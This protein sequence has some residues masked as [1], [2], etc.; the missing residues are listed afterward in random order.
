MSEASTG[1]IWRVLGSL[2]DVPIYVT[3]TIGTTSA[4]GGI[5]QVSGNVSLSGSNNFVQIA[6]TG[7]NFSAELVSALSGSNTLDFD[8]TPFGGTSSGFESASISKA[9]AGMFYEAIVSNMSSS[10]QYF[11]LFDRTTTPPNGEPPAA[12][13]S[14]YVAASSSISISPRTGHYFTA[15]IVWGWST[16]YEFFTG[17]YAGSAIVYTK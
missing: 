7:S 3:G 4:A 10:A 8:A 1:E 2:P 9:T 5:T 11:Q 16:R 15:G 6:G 14:F 17:A 12:G 13:M